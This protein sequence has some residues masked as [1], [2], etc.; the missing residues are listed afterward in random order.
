MFLKGCSTNL[1]LY[2]FPDLCKDNDRIKNSEIL[3]IILE[4]SITCVE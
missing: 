4:S 2:Q 1:I 3:I